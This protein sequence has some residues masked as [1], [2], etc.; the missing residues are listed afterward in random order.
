MNPGTDDDASRFQDQPT[1][2]EFLENFSSST[3]DVHQVEED[4]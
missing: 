3:S 4:V 1:A 2:A